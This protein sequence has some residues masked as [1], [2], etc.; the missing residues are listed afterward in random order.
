MTWH[1]PQKNHQGKSPRHVEVSAK[2][3]L[4]STLR[5]PIINTPYIR[6]PS[7]LTDD[8]LWNNNKIVSDYKEGTDASYLI[9]KHYYMWNRSGTKRE[10]HEL[11]IIPIKKITITSEE[12]KYKKPIY[13][14]L[15]TQAPPIDVT[16]NDDG[17][18][19]MFNGH[20]RLKS[21]ISRKEKTIF[22]E[23]Y[24]SR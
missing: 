21:A 24:P 4:Y 5:S 19:R 10:L 11:T 2:K 1:E 23:I 6:P 7:E 20:R 8:E 3:S 17:T 12:L 16:R 14:E 9:G 13:K 15:T 22:A 18:Y